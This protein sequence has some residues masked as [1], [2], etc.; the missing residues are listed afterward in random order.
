MEG[1]W[2]GMGRWGA[3]AQIVDPNR[4]AKSWTEIINANP[5]QKSWTPKMM[6]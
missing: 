5:G 1:V 4:G 3:K 6:D 2:W